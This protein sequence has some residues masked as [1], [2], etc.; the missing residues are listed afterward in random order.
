MKPQACGLEL[1]LLALAGALVRWLRR[2]D[3][4]M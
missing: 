3:N 1:V 4:A 2:N